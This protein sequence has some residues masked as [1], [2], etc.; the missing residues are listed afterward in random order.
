MLFF[1]GLLPATI[2]AVVGYFVLFASSRAEGVVRAFG[3]AL[4]VWIFVAAA[5]PPVAGAYATLT[6]ASPFK[7]MM[8]EHASWHQTPAAIGSGG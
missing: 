3:R 5:V 4:A 1:V 2:F 8:A 6:G 7:E